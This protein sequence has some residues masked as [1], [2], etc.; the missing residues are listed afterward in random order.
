[1]VQKILG[2][3]TS[4]I[5]IKNF[6]NIARMLTSLQCYRLGVDILDK[7]VMIMKNWSTNA[8]SDCS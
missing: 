6:F 4:Q 1:V 3:P 2:I 8:I 7:L 5:E